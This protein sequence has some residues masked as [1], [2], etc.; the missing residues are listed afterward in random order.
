[1]YDDC[2]THRFVYWLPESWQSESAVL[3]AF[4]ELLAS[5]HGQQVE[6]LAEIPSEAA[7][8][9]GSGRG[10]PDVITCPLIAFDKGLND[11]QFALLDCPDVQTRDTGP[12]R[13]KATLNP[14]VAFVMGAAKVCSA[15]LY[16]WEASRMRESLF[17]DLLDELRRASPGVRISLLINKIE[18]VCGEPTRTF[19]QSSVQ[20]VLADLSGTPVD[21]YGAF[22]HCIA[23]RPGPAGLVQPG[24]DDL[25]PPG[26]V[27][28]HIDG[29]NCHPQFFQLSPDAAANAADAVHESR[30]LHSALAALPPAELQQT[31]CTAMIRRLARASR[32]AVSHVRKLVK[33]RSHTAKERQR[34]LLDAATGVF[35]D[36]G[37]GKPTQ[38][39]SAEFLA[40]FHD[41]L[42]RTAPPVVRGL[43]NARRFTE[44]VITK[45]VKTAVS[46]VTST[47]SSWIG[48]VER[49]K[50][51]A[52]EA[53]QTL[54]DSAGGLSIERHS[55]LTLARSLLSQRWFP[56]GIDEDSVVAAIN[57]VHAAVAAV[58]AEPPRAELDA[59]ARKMWKNITSWEM[60]KVLF[61]TLVG[62]IGDVLAIGGLML[63]V[64]DG[65][66]SY[67]GTTAMA[68]FISTQFIAVGLGAGGLVSW[69]NGFES[70][71]ARFNTIP[72]LA[73]FF[74][75]L[76]D[77]FGVPRPAN[78]TDREVVYAGSGKPVRYRLT[79]PTLG[80]LRAVCSLGDQRQWRED[81]SVA[82]LQS[83]ATSHE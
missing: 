59:Q 37:T 27:R 64:A 49:A 7:A 80:P 11:R 22:N 16:V 72:C 55:S 36:P 29:G 38:P 54:F 25:T 66:L 77:V 18:P 60:T 19:S 76:C 8:Q 50:E 34:H 53:V 69:L 17:G 30:F 82:K 43:L 75:A 52:T 56:T 45:P 33:D 6:Y 26:L 13:L 20:A 74:A 35:T 71:L 9:Y 78:F 40:A 39:L 62:T 32:D 10:K 42:T 57:K 63:V 4:R 41:S 31:H 5:A 3:E 46:T 83:W 12:A 14:R 79:T 48:G 73:N 70:T 23:S 15:F 44:S 67:F 65:G 2:G 24:W 1:V 68:N 47:V 28:R 81:S 58:P 51:Q 61:A 21:V